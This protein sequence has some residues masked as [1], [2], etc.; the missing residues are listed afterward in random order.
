MEK[1]RDRRIF[2]HCAAN[3]RVSVFVYLYRCLTGTPPT[4]AATALHAIWHPNPTW[5]ALIDEVLST[6]GKED[7]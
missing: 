5:Q 4:E 3:M 1:Y 2:V 7:S 6:A